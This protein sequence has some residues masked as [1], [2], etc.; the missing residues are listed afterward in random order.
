MKRLRIL[1]VVA[2]SLSTA[3]AIWASCVADC[4]DEYDSAV[5]SCKVLYGAPKESDDLQD[6]IQH[7]KSEYEDCINGCPDDD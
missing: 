1:A 4:K 2:L 5:R 3:A 6:C 7:A